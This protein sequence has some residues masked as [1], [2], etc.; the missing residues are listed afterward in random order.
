MRG[1]SVQV[2]R[3][4]FTGEYDAHGIEIVEYEE[5]V[6]VDRVLVMPS[7][8]QDN[9]SGDISHGKV[10]EATRPY[11][12]TQ[13]C[14]FTFPKTYNLPLR[15]ARIYVPYLDETFDVVGDPHPIAHG[16]PTRW[17]YSVQGVRVDG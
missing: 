8:Q 16:C 7:T 9:S 12:V 1:I 4:I 2:T 6:T 11:G 15:G 14:N 10:M 3:A 17:N 5:P 13:L